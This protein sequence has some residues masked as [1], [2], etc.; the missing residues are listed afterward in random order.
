M[1]KAGIA[2]ALLALAAPSLRAA[3]VAFREFDP[4][5]WRPDGEAMESLSFGLALGDQPLSSRVEMRATVTP[6]SCEDKETAR[7]GIACWDIDGTGDYWHFSLLKGPDRAGAKHGFLLEAYIGRELGVQSRFKRV[8]FENAGAW[9]WDKP[10]ELL[11]RV[12][13]ERVEGE[14]RDAATGALLHRCAYEP[15]PGSPIGPGAPALRVSGRFRARVENIVHNS[16]NDTNVH[17][18]Q[19]TN[20][21]EI[22]TPVLLVHGEK[23]HS[24]YFSEY[25]FEKMTGIAVRGESATVGNK[26]LL[27]IPGASH[28][29]LYDD[30][31]GVIP[32]DRIAE[33]FRES[34]K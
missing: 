25:A 21:N 3:R 33:F 11:L 30:E 24:R 10:V 22:E 7:V 23:A 16:A 8:A 17:K 32:H 19:M 34:M 20:A 2:L 5:G 4:L 26:E 27:I 15:R 6:R 14:A 9:E 1:R 28:V 18:S 29:D 12:T 13:P 31:A